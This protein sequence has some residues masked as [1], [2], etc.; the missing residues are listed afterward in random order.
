M[1]T[2][3]YTV[4]DGEI[5]A[6]D[7]AGAE[8]DYVPDPL[9]S[10]VALLDNTQAQTDT[11][12]HWPYGEERSRTGTTATPFQFVGTFGYYRDDSARSYARARSL[13]VRTGRWLSPDPAQSGLIWVYARDTPTNLVDPSGLH[14]GPEDDVVLCGKR[15]WDEHGNWCGP[16][17]GGG[18]RK[19][20]TLPPCDCIDVACKAHDICLGK[21]PP[22]AVKVKC[23]AALC[24][25]A[26]NCVNTRC[27]SPKPFGGCTIKSYVEFAVRARN[28]FC[29]LGWTGV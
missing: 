22:R 27:A 12:G 17:M 6:E 11:F 9:G 21:N 7:R 15:G 14:D 1:A 25:A 19:G 10:T 26:K 16:A 3:R 23:H 4:L 5:V 28:V 18:S 2:V 24:N 20:G 13:N 8:R 29:N